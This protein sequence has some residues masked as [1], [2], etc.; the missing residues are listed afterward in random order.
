MSKLR[1]N[2]KNKGYST[3]II[4]KQ[5]GKYLKKHSLLIVLSFFMSAVYAVGSLLVP[6]MVGK[7]IDLMIDINNVDFK[8][9]AKLILITSVIIAVSAVFQWLAELINNKIV[10]K[11]VRD[12]RK[13]AFEKLQHLPLS[14]ID[15]H[16]YGDTVS[17]VI[18][19]VEKVADGLLLGL[20]QLFSGVVTILT[21]LVFI[22]LKSPLIA[23]LVFILTPI[24]LF[25]AKFIAKRTYSKFKEQA[26][27]SGEATA[28]IN[29]VFTNQ[30]TVKAFSQEQNMVDKFNA[31]SDKLEK[32]S[33]KATFFSSLTNPST[34]FINS[35]VYIAV[36]V[37]GAFICIK[38]SSVGGAVTFTVGSLSALLAFANKYTKPFNE[39]SGVVTEMQNAL[40]CASR[41]FELLNSPAESV[42]ENAKTLEYV[43]GNV[44]LK[45]VA[46]SYDKNKELIKNLNLEATEGTH[47]AI[48]GP[49]GCGKSTLINLLMR[50]YDIDE[51]E[52]L[53]DGNNTAEVTRESLRNGFGMVLQET[54]LKAGTIKEN[55][56]F[57]KPDA[58]DEEIIAACKASSAHN[59][60]VKMPNGYDT[61]IEE[62]SGLSQG[63]RQLI[64]ISRVM[65]K[66]PPI[67]ILDEATS[68]IDTRT[69]IK[70]QKDFAELTKGKT[71]FIV[72]HRLS[73]IEDA[74]IIL[75]MKDGKIIEQG[76]HKELLAK[77]GFYYEL[78]NSISPQSEE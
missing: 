29:E 12:I 63:Q 72:A 21:T 24:S 34:R 49:T 48:V 65:L 67:L 18:T 1:K 68:S 62:D 26:V 42:F 50:F 55:I 52:I 11:L 45:N 3:A 9:I 35:I 8:A 59:F 58:S 6:V 2:K 78:Y 54:W 74:D 5:L 60:I 27:I 69:E 25:T 41:V 16:A 61:Y 76:N 14:Y 32:C 75:V 39:I 53:I 36:A 64:C 13:D 4:A 31:I 7:M 10:F 51:G 73:T 30:K 37:A 15:S 57:G 38:Q 66:L 56:A 22:A 44:S 70:I 43:K 33:V 17:R 47:V 40:A 19:D 77:G 23:L 71:S 28:M 46:F 20:A